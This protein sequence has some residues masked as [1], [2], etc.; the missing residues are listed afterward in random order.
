M[1]LARDSGSKRSLIKN[2]VLLHSAR[3]GAEYGW[4]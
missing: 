4:A 2:L 1:S 3:V